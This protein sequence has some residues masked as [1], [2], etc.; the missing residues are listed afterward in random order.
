MPSLVKDVYP[1]PPPQKIKT[2][3]GGPVVENPPAKAGDKG[4]ILG[5]GQ[6]HMPRGS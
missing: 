2:F 4:L 3:P 1:P 6:S 5:L